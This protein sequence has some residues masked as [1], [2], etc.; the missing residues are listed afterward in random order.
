M[1]APTALQRHV[2]YFDPEGTGLITYGQ[3]YRGI[4]DLGVGRAWS[5][6]LSGIIH[7]ALGW[8]TQ[9]RPTLTIDIA[10]I[11]RGKHPSD[12]G[13]FDDEGN[14]VPERFD[15][16]FTFA[17]ETD[18]ETARV[19]EKEL[20]AYMKSEGPQSFAGN[21]FS[22][23][24]ARLFFCVAADTTKREDG[25]EVPAITRRRLKVFYDGRL[26]P[27]I[28]RHRRIRAAAHA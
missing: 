17:G 22:G 13:I 14:F 1:A 4:R 11:H 10:N 27:A 18:D 15:A 28:R 6:I 20:R 23:A 2:L 7:L 9:R 21:F 8:V 24:E 26:L 5:A 16:L 25:R 19:T 12:S 3:T